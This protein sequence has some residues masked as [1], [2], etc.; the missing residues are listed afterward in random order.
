MEW[1]IE[2]AFNSEFLQIAVAS[3][4]LLF[5]LQMRLDIVVNVL[6]NVYRTK[7]DIY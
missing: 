1:E 3:D 7:F 4:N 2:K 6:T 5:C